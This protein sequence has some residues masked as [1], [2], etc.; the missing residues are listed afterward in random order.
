MSSL[1]VEPS[2]ALFASKRWPL[3]GKENKKV[4]EILPEFAY[5]FEHIPIEYIVIGKTLPMEKISE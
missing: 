1:F 5:E 4:A 2:L 3:Y